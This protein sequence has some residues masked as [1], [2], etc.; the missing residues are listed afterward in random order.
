MDGFLTPEGSEGVPTDLRILHDMKALLQ[1]KKKPRSFNFN[2]HFLIRP[3]ANVIFERAAA[4][5]KPKAF[6][7]ALVMPNPANT[8]S[9]D[10]FGGISQKRSCQ[11]CLMLKR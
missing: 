3:T 6:S 4:A 8:G 1:E 7:T 9:R 11:K 2:V 10:M 5:E